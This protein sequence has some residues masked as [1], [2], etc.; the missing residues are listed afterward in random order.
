MNPPFKRRQQGW[1]RK[2]D[3]GTIVKAAEAKADKLSTMAV[4]ELQA[5]VDCGELTDT[6]AH[7]DLRAAVLAKHRTEMD[8]AREILDQAT[9]MIKGFDAKGL[10]AKG[11]TT[12]A[13]RVEKKAVVDE[14]T[15]MAKAA[16]IVIESRSLAQVAERRSWGL[17]VP[18][19]PGWLE[20]LSDQ[21]LDDVSKGKK[22]RGMVAT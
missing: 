3:L 20:S 9:A 19:D 21:E 22:V 16:K 18:V 15:A 7:E 5:R 2:V 6:Q 13:I 8:L 12:E 1:A 11:V 10:R 17:D 14:A 4:P